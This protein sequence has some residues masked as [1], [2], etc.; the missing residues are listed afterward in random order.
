M[1]IK[2]ARFSQRQLLSDPGSRQI[3]SRRGF[4]VVNELKV[5]SLSFEIVK[6]VWRRGEARCDGLTQVFAAQ[7]TRSADRFPSHLNDA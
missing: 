3:E 4:D 7:L 2:D 5:N 6:I 1:K